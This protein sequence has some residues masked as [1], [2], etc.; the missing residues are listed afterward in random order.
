MRNYVSAQIAM[1]IFQV[2]AL[3]YCLP[4]PVMKKIVD[5]LWR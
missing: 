1:T 2:I 5:V 3:C 4:E